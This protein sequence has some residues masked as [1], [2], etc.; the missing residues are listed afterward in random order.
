M[1]SKINR[2]EVHAKYGGRCAYCGKE[3]SMKE[4]QVDHIQP[5][6]IMYADPLRDD[7]V[8]LNP[9]CKRCNHYK[10]ALPLEDFRRFWLGGLKERLAKLYTVKVAIDYGIVTLQEWDRKFYFEKIG[11]VE[12]V[13]GRDV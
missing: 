2:T 6:R 8:N 13:D 9:S 7:P 10:R 1:S 4:M 12:L 5:K 11:A 3:I